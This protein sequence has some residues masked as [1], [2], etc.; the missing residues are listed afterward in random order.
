MTQTE[1]TRTMKYVLAVYHGT[2]Y[3]L[4]PGWF[5]H[6]TP[7]F[8]QNPMSTSFLRVRPTNVWGGGLFFFARYLR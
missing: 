1:R 8:L 6:K 5:E 2:K 7:K 4:Y 3:Y